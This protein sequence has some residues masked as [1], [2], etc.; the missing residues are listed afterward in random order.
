[1]ASQVYFG[2]ATKQTWIK[3]PA[4]G[5]KASSIGWATQSQ[6]LDGRAFVRRSAAS[7]RQYDASWL[8][9]MNDPDL[10]V[11]LQTIKDFADGLYGDG[12]FYFVD[13]YAATSNIMPP[14]WAAPMLAES[15]WLELTENIVPTYAVSTANNNFP[16]KY[17]QYVATGAFESEQKLTLI[18]PSTHKLHF[19]WHGPA[20]GSTTGI[21]IVPYKRADGL[22]DTAL[23]PTKITSGGTLRTNTQV[24]G[25]TYSRVE[26]FLATSGAATVNIGAMIAQILVAS[27]SPAAGGFVSGRGHT[28]LEFAQSP[29]I[30]YYSANVNN[31]QIGMSATWIEV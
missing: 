11:S 14:N 30:D 28:G 15:G 12:P 22:A 20:T 31:G 29:T 21:R 8:G 6:L 4:S 13:P 23:N 7:H 18:I 26:I 3:S 1:M 27:S 19:G 24:S 9:S 16:G 17:A 10:S 2:T 25:S 5:M